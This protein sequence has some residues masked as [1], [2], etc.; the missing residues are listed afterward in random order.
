MVAK[1]QQDKLTEI[2]ENIQDSYDYFKNNFK[3]F[4]DYRRFVFETNLSVDE[5]NK[6]ATL[7]K[8]PIQFNISE[9]Y[10]SRLCGE[11]SKQEPSFKASAKND[12]INPDPK[13]IQIIEGHLI[14]LLEDTKPDALEYNIYRDQLSGGFSV[15]KVIT[16]Y[17]DDESFYQVI[18]LKRVFDPTLCGFDPLA[19]APHKGD[20]EYCYE[21]FPMTQQQFEMYYPNVDINQISYQRNIT[22]FDSLH[23]SYM[24]GLKKIVLVVDYYAKVKKKVKLVYLAPSLD[25]RFKRTMTMKDYQALLDEYETNNIIAKPPVIIKERMSYQ[26]SVCRYRLIEN[27]IIEYIETNYK[28]LP[29]VFVDGNSVIIS[30][31]ST[32][33]SSTRQ[34]CR[35]YLYHAKD[36]QRLMNFGGQTLAAELQN[37]VQSKYILAEQ[38]IPEKYAD[39]W[40][41][42]QQASVLIYNPYVANDPQKPLPPPQPVQRTPIPPEISAT[43]MNMPQL[44][45]NILGSYDASL[46]I[47]NNQLSGVAIVEGATQ[48]NSA[49][50]PYV[51]NFLTA[52]NQVALIVMDLIPKY[53]VNARTIPVSMP[54]GKRFYQK[55]NDPTDP[56]S[57]NVGELVNGLNVKVEAGVN[58]EVQKSRALQSLVQLGQAFP[59][60]NAM[61]NQYGLEIVFDNL[62][63]RG[64]EQLKE[65][66]KKFNQEMQMQKQQAQQ[67]GQV[68][69]LVMRNQIEQQK[70]QMQNEHKQADLRLDQQRIQLD[71]LK[72]Q[73]EH[74]KT[75]LEAKNDADYNQVQT[76]KANADAEAAIANIAIQVRDQAHNHAKDIAQHHHEVFK[77]AH[78]M[79]SQ[80]DAS[81]P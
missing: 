80:N 43:F 54:D 58:F 47:N 8:P 31:S 55:I 16:D 27:Q 15:L 73:D 39:A 51:V 34:I 1:R 26:T 79:F 19:R 40:T 56:N 25:P 17:E 2:K 13:Q 67:Q 59:A 6:L 71:A 69:P 53:Y 18:N 50:M 70:L 52:L 20:G 57:I 10:L 44:M 49:A 9:A 29:L 63:I 78:E 72:L 81:Q 36:A 46:G 68:N 41:N 33:S 3:T 14:A 32:D 23:W 65:M 76:A 61:I 22:N 30:S 37:M 77:S 48:S 7:N 5:Q 66:A 12:D 28:Y 4:T 38:A 60:I 42:P 21:A 45:Q 74:L 24:N 11:F 62:D 35:P 64:V 75:V